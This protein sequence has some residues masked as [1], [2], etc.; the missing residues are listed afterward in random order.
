[1]REIRFIVV[2]CTAGNQ[3]ESMADLIKGFRARGWRHNGYHDVLDYLGEVHNITPYEQIANGVEGHNRYAIH[4]SYTG[5]IGSHGKPMDNRTW[6][7]KEGL[8]KNLKKL[9]GMFPQA[10]IVGHRD[11]SPDTNHDGKISTWEYIK[12]CPCFDAIPEY[13]N[14]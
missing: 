6:A 9:K 3:K 12:Y 2:H 4:V 11:F 10:K 1:M 8:I 5:G 14:L 7:Q 13:A